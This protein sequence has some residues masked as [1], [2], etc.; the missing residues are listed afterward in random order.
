MVKK[1]SKISARLS[2]VLR[3]IA[4][5]HHLSQVAEEEG[6]SRADLKEALVA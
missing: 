3:K 4:N 2:L 1:Q 5:D 6:C